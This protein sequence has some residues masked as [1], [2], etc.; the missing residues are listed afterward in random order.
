MGGL[1][2]PV[3]GRYSVQADL[4]WPTKPQVELALGIDNAIDDVLGA[5]GEIDVV[6][7]SLPI[8]LSFSEEGVESQRAFA[9][10]RRSGNYGHFALRKYRI[11]SS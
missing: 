11:N 7:A 1:A 10:T 9:G 3:L 8:A 2:A 6:S 5:A 4:A